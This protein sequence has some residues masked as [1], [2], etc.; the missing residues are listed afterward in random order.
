MTAKSV[1]VSGASGLIGNALVKS[2]RADGVKVAT[3]V[4]SAA[5]GP[6]QIVW[7]PNRGLDP[8]VIEGAD[9]IVCLN[10]AS[11]AR[12]PWTRSYRRELFTSR[13]QPTSSIASA[14][15]KVGDSS[16]VFITASAVG[17]YGSQPGVLL[18][19]ES[20]P[21]VTYLAKLSRAWEE[22]ASLAAGAARIVTIRT[23]PVI[24]PKAVLR[25]LVALTKAGMAGPLG[26]GD[27]YWPWISL[28]DQVRAIRHLLDR[29]IAGPVNLT[30]PV[31]A[32]MNQTGRAIA[33]VLKRP[34]GLRVPAW[35]L[36]MTVGADPVDSLLL[37][38]AQVVPRVLLDSHFVFTSATVEEAVA[39]AIR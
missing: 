26:S 32:T 4:R 34:Y 28:L 16:K 22:S 3:L 39:A 23:A 13:I 24:H 33:A 27:Q 29:D 30:G 36:R 38:D 20:S 35:A 18:T 11:I 2:L 15:A 8:E 7:D 37:A 14:L 25:P 5:S 31:S 17:Y 6:D 1:V 10:G 21:G 12:L 19:E 9:A